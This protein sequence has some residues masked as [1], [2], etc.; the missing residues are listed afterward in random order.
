MP[1]SQGLH[2]ALHPGNIPIGAQGHIGFTSGKKNQVDYMQGKFP[3][4]PVRFALSLQ[5]YIF[6]K[7][8]EPQILKHILFLPLKIRQMQMATAE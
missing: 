5:D 3:T 6:S 8:K 2:L 4:V 1:Q 7:K